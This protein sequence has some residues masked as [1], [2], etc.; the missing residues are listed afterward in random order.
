V[1]RQVV[2]RTVR[3]RLRRQVLWNGNVEPP[4][5]TILTDREHIVR[6]AW[7]THHRSSRRI[8][9]L[10][11]QRPELVIVRLRSWREARQWLDRLDQWS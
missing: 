9:D 4:L 5:R 8:A 1:M 6:W 11:R 10:R 2:V 7:K 3:R